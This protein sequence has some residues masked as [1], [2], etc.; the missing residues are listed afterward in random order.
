M[1]IFGEKWMRKYMQEWNKEPGL[2]KELGIIKFNSIIAYGFI[3][4]DSPRAVIQVCK[5]K[6]VSA[7][8]YDD[9]A[10]NWDLRADP[11]HWHEWM[12]NPPGMMALGMAYSSRALKF[13]SGDYAS[14]IKDPRMAVPFIKSFDVMGR[15]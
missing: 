3:N 11:E 6:V 2:T 9:E 14:M 13:M 1:E 5:G 7:G 15:V 4:E 12:S 8:D 10:V